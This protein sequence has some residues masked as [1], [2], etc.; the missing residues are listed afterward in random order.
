VVAAPWLDPGRVLTELGV[1]PGMRAAATQIAP[2][3]PPDGKYASTSIPAI[4]LTVTARSSYDPVV[5]AVQLLAAIHRVHGDSVVVNSRRMG[6]LLGTSAVWGRIVTN[7]N[8][9]PLVM[10]WEQARRGLQAS[11]TRYLLYE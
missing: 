9:G 4:E 8:L 6:Q 5:T 3:D 2:I 11:I 7:G 10:A 1:V